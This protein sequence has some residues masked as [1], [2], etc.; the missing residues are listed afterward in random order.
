M[1]VYNAEAETRLKFV[2]VIS[3][4]TQPGN[5]V[6]YR[7]VIEVLEGVMKLLL[8]KYKAV[9]YEKRELESFK[10]LHV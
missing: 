6:K 5:G 10:P 7:L 3:C 2:R 8:D 4:E 9:V 1:T